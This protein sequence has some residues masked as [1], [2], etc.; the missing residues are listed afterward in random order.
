MTIC[1][2]ERLKEYIHKVVQ[3][4]SYFIGYLITTDFDCKDLYPLL[5]YHS[6]IWATRL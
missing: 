6:T 5:K 3:R 1:E 2:K 4:V